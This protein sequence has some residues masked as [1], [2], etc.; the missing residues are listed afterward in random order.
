MKYRYRIHL[1]CGGE[2]EDVGDVEPSTYKY[3]LTHCDT[4]IICKDSDGKQVIITK[5]QIEYIEVELI[6]ETD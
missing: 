3:R 5:D 6:N 1:I 2:F 4:F